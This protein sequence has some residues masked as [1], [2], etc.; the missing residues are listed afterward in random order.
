M[1]ILAMEELDGT[2]VNPDE[3]ISVTLAKPDDPTNKLKK[4]KRNQ[5]RSGKIKKPSFSLNFTV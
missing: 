3:V 4:M 1:V 2:E 5:M